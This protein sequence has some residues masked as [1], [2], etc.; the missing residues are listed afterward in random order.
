[1]ALCASA[2]GWES[3]PAHARLRDSATARVSA[4]TRAAVLGSP[5]SRSMK[6]HCVQTASHPPQ[7]PSLP[8]AASTLDP[9]AGGPWVSQPVSMSSPP[10]SG[11]F[12][13]GTRTR[14]IQA[15]SGYP[16]LHHRLP[17]V[18]GAGLKADPR[19]PGRY[20]HMNSTDGEALAGTREWGAENRGAAEGSG[21]TEEGVRGQVGEEGG[22]G[23]GHWGL[24][25]RLQGAAARKGRPRGRIAGRRPEVRGSLLKPEASRK[26]P[27]WARRD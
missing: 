3:G 5:L 25:D 7:A 22:A 2:V 19:Y 4:L 15:K 9:S 11:L 1:M 13:P 6:T 14:L 10:T 27:L 24:R 21:G 20:P 12:H 8:A 17:G 26:A 16:S 18:K 23:R